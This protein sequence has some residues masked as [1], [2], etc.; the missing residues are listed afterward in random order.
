MFEI[1]K[2]KLNNLMFI[3]TTNSLSITEHETIC[4]QINLLDSLLE[5]FC[6][7]QQEAHDNG[8]YGYDEAEFEDNNPYYYFSDIDRYMLERRDL[9]EE[10]TEYAHNTLH[11]T[12]GIGKSVINLDSHW[13][14][15]DE[16]EAFR[17]IW[18]RRISAI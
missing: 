13:F 8:Y 12:R 9:I 16:I 7:S 11:F 1:I 2:S 17:V 10:Q 6:S 14:T 5:E 3:L 18:Q 4:I 15:S